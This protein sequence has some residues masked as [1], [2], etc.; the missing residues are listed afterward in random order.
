MT[1]GNRLRWGFLCGSIGLL[2][3]GCQGGPTAGFG[4]RVPGPMVA[5]NAPEVEPGLRN[6]N[7]AGG[8]VVTGLTPAGTLVARGQLPEPT[9]PQPFN[10]ATAVKTP[11][12]LPSPQT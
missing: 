8:G 1:W 2:A 9:P 3:T 5:D 12:A 7:N 10:P 11:L 4:G 6:R